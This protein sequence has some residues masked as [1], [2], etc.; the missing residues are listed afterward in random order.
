MLNHQ[1]NHYLKLGVIFLVAALILSH[2][3]PFTRKKELSP[4]QISIGELK[5]RLERNFLGLETLRGRARIQ[6]QTPEMAYEAFSEVKIQMPDSLFLKVEVIFGIDVGQFFGNRKSFALYSP[7]ANVFYDGM[8]DSL[9]LGKFFQIDLTY[10]DLLEAF[11][12]TPKIIIGKMTPLAVDNG[13][14][15]LNSVT[16]EGLHRYW[17]DPEK[18]VITKYQFYDR[19]GTLQI[20]KHFKRFKKYGDIYLPKSIQIR[21]PA[22][23]Q[24]FS[25]YYTSQKTNKTVSPEEFEINVPENCKRINL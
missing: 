15:K 22:L 17:I 13:R 20:E 8:M 19:T 2:C 23:K 24:Y 25:L 1:P 12:G 11:T 3:S 6:I 9:D 18:L 16:H 5:E 14:F 21:R 4:D 10:D 7:Q